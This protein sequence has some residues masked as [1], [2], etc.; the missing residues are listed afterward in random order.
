M[1]E[2]IQDE[3]FNEVIQQTQISIVEFGAEWCAPCKRQL[4]VLESIAK[5]NPEITVAKIDVDTNPV[6]KDKYSISSVPTIL[7]FFDGV[8]YA[9]VVGATPKTTLLRYI[10]PMRK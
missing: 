1:I 4:P 9:R 2:E 8:E 7:A 10:D 6:A 3:T 5:E